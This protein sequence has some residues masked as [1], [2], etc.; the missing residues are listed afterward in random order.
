MKFQSLLSVGAIAVATVLVA[1]GCATRG[2]TAEGQTSATRAA[3]TSCDTNGVAQG[4]TA[5][6]IKLGMFTPLTGPLAAPGNGALKGF[7]FALDKV[8]ETGGV[9][10]R[11]V[12]VVAEDDQYDAAVAQQAARRLETSEG[13]FAFAGG[14]GTPNFVGV[15]PFIKEKRIPAV[16]PYAPSNQVGVMENPNVYMIW[17]NFI[18]EYNVA[19]SWLLK[20]QKPVS[21]SFVQ[22]VGDVGDDALTGINKALEGSGL[23]IGT[24]QTVE[25]TMTDFSAVAQALKNKNSDLVAL[26][27]GPVIV[28]QVIAAMDQIGYKPKLLA[29]S[30]ITDDSFLSEYGDAVDGMTV[31]TKVAPFASEDPLVQ[32]FVADYTKTT[33][34]APTMWNAVGY[35]QAL[36]TIKALEDAPALTRD[37]LEFSLETMTDFKTGLIPPVTFGPN[38]RQGTNAVGVARIENGKAVQVA[39]FQTVSGK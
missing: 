7:Q 10:G 12:K 36:V 2:D 34:A 38:S 14:I 3:R 4:I 21:I 37:C 24:T 23:T 32:K 5:S 35:T 26:I 39:P 31:P 25:P 11:Q 13:V 8:N 1:T 6:E 16:G 20:E 29:Q 18:D 19:L 33:G 28:G 17:P 9:Q 30:D 22:Q 27:A 15:L